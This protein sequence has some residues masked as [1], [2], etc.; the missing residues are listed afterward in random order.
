MYQGSP[1][2]DEP[3]QLTSCIRETINKYTEDLQDGSKIKSSSDSGHYGE[4]VKG[5]KKGTETH[6]TINM[7]N[8]RKPG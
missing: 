1:R 3:I 7:K 8:I 5:I 4:D 2:T 6:V